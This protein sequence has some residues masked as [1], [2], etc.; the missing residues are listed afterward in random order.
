MS[1]APSAGTAPPITSV[2]RRGI[3]YVPPSERWGSPR[4]L[5]WMWAGAIWNVEF[6]VVGVLGVVV[7]GLSLTQAIVVIIAGNLSYLL[8][9]LAS[10]QGP[11]AGTT[12]FAVS[13]APFGPKGNRVPSL[14]NWITQVGFETEGISLI[15]FSA[16]TLAAETGLNPVPTW[17][18]AVFLVVAV[19]AQAVL[20][21]LGHAAVLRV[22]RLLAVPFVVLFTVMAA[23]VA[24]RYQSGPPGASWGAMTIFLSLVIAAG[25]LS[26]TENAS[27]Y[28]RYLPSATSN[29]GIVVAVALGCL[30]PSVLLEMLGAALG[31]E[32]PK[33][34]ML[35]VTGL[36]AGFPAWFVWPYL[37]FAIL[38]IFAINTLDLYSSGVTLQ[39]L[40]PRLNRISCVAIDTVIC[41]G[42]AAYAVFSL[43]FYQSLYDFLLFIVVWLGPWCAIYLVDSW[44]RRNRYDPQSLLTVTGGRYYG[45]GGV[46][47]QALV[48]Q[49]VGMV[50]ACSWLNAYPPYVGPLARRIGGSLGSDLSVFLGLFVGGATYWLLAGRQVRAEGEA[51]GDPLS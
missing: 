24:H 6:L 11:R 47:W 36:T 3:E 18:K 26:W 25:G 31:T 10:L 44:L 4:G 41:L 40:V 16:I 33:S 22:L 34:A 21:L 48:A 29:T 46:R 9:G 45:K 37:V 5:F 39:S 42:A 15:V 27:D 30:I 19:A 2:E 43:S 35:D 20:P 8:T 17:L 28:S 13:R 38:Q 50:A 32:L 23:Y 14:F 1:T 51:T 12:C 7:F 49:A